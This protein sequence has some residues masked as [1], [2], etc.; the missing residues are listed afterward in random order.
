MD[1]FCGTPKEAW[2]PVSRG[3]LTHCF[4][5]ATLLLP[6]FT[7]QFQFTLAAVI[8]S[9]SACPT[10]SCFSRAHTGCVALFN[11]ACKLR[12]PALTALA[13][14]V[15]TLMNV[16]T[17]KSFPHSKSHRCL[18]PPPPPPR[19]ASSPTHSTLFLQHESCAPV[20]ACSHPPCCESLAAF[21]SLCAL[22]PGQVFCFRYAMEVHTRAACLAHPPPL[23]ASICTAVLPLSGA[24]R[25]RVARAPRHLP[26]VVLLVGHL[27]HGGGARRSSQLRAAHLLDVRCRP[28]KSHSDLMF[29][30]ADTAQWP[31][32]LTCQSSSS[33][34]ANLVSALFFTSRSPTGCSTCA[35]HNFCTVSPF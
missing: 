34:A 27:P 4:R 21:L 22:T 10:C 16:P 33:T 31:P 19:P 20:L 15:W 32:A 35:P 11:R 13:P 8:S 24:R 29:H 26:V 7:T 6:N 17:R 25:H 9:Y 3:W 2:G 1:S 23:T 30:V 18:R 12:A 14:Q 28:S 5:C